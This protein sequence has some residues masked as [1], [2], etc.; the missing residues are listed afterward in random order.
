MT[1]EGKFSEDLIKACVTP[2]VKKG[3]PKDPLNYS[4]ISVTS[5]L[6]KIFEKAF[7]S[8][9]TKL[10]ESEQLVSISHFGYRKQI[11]TIDAILKSTQQ[12]R[13]ELN[14]KKLLEGCF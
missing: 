5:A 6:S 4:P 10:L 14:R 3:N 7:S 12:I 11:S 1:T 9:I 2:F 8:Q 13:L